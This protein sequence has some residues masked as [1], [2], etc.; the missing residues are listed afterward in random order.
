MLI[1]DLQDG[2]MI[3]NLMKNYLDIKLDV[4]SIAQAKEIV[5][6]TNGN[7]FIT[8][9][10]KQQIKSVLEYANE[11]MKHISND[12]RKEITLGDYLKRHQFM[13]TGH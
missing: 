12:R 1:K 11:S 3:E 6:N 13:N 7:E 10:V 4:I 8:Q 2:K 9:R 5:H